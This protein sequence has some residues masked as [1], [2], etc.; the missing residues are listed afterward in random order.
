M[1]KDV[2]TLLTQVEGKLL[3]KMHEKPSQET[4]DRLALFV[5]F[6]DWQ[7]FQRELHQGDDSSPESGK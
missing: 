7:S 3:K 6:Q 5:G 1:K 2:R 4:L